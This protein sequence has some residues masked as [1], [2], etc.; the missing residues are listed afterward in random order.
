MKRAVA[1]CAAIAVVGVLAV[2]LLLRPL[3]AHAGLPGFNHDWAWPPT[4]QQAM[5]QFVSMLHPYVDTNFGGENFFIGGVGLRALMALAS[6]TGPGMGLRLVLWLVLLVAFAG[7]YRL[8]RYLAATP[9]VAASIATIFTASPVTA[10]E[11][12][13]GHVSYMFSYAL[14]PWLLSSVLV[15]AREKRPLPGLLAVAFLAPLG[16]AQPQ[17]II[18]DPVVCLVALAFAHDRQSRGLVLACAAYA[19]LATPYT[20]ALAAVGHPAAELRT[21]RT[22]LHWI[23]ANSGSIGAAF[24]AT[25]YHPAYDR[26]APQALIVARAIGG[27]LLWIAAVIGVVRAPASR[28]AFVVALLAILLCAGLNGLFAAPLAFAFAHISA[29]ALFRE[30]YHFSALVMLGLCVCLASA[31]FRFAN[32]ALPICTFL[33]AVPQLTG[34]FWNAVGWYDPAA[35]QPIVSRIAQAP[36]NGYVLFLPLLQP[37][38][39]RGEPHA[40][41]DVDAFSVDGHASLSEFVPVQPLSQLDFILRRHPANAAALLNRLGIEFVVIRLDRTSEYF[42]RIEPA[43]NPL[44]VRHGVPSE[45]FAWLLRR[46]HTIAR[47]GEIVLAQAGNGEIVHSALTADAPFYRL[48]LKS[49][50]A[51]SAVV[52][53]RRGWVAGT[54]WQWWNAAFMGPIDPGVFSIGVPWRGIGSDVKPLVVAAPQGARLIEGGSVEKIS[55][56]NEYRDISVRGSYEFIANGGAMIAGTGERSSRREGAQQGETLEVAA[57]R[58]SGWVVRDASGRRMPEVSSAWDLEWLLPLRGA[59]YSLRRE[60]S[61]LLEIGLALQYLVWAL[62]IASAIA[63]LTL[64]VS[65]ESS[66]SRAVV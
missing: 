11:L 61:P 38:G 56:S 50:R 18:F 25:G 65:H 64:T 33:Y 14:L 43:L 42:T 57:L 28:L 8:A 46:L 3:L 60:L 47:S 54:S 5:T 24:L 27:A 35:M 12:A 22:T 51:S 55:P 1:G 39:Q 31:R 37:I 34:G 10:N 17:F 16:A 23:A 9:A 49:P 63:L 48:G 30:L 66:H 26:L 29:T 21:D 2:G 36:G 40:G 58:G 6:I 15:V 45:N 62:A 53:P 13:A 19:L 7:A 52:D 41:A 4:E 20:L 44:V 32:V 59:P